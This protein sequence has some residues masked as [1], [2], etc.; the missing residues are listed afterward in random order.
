MNKTIAIVVGLILLGALLL[1]S[2]TY[3]VQYHEVAIKTRFGQT[4]D[5]SIIDEPGLKFRLPLFADKVTTLD[6]RLQ[7]RESPLETV[8]TS[9]GQ[10]VLVKAF[11]LWQV[12]TS[13]PDGQGPLR[14]TKSFGSIDEANA[15]MADQ[16]K[17][18]MRNGLS[19]FTFN[20]LIGT[21]SRLADAEAAIKNEMMGL[22]I[23]GVKPVT[24]GVSQL[25]LPPRTAQAV[26]TRMQTTR[27]VQSENE[28][29]KGQAQAQSIQN[30]AKTQADKIRS[31]ADHRAAEI[32]A[33]GERDAAKYYAL[34]NEEREL[35]IF[36]QEI[37]GLR[38]AL[39]RYVTVVLPANFAPFH[40]MNL[41]TPTNGNGVPIPPTTQPG[42]AGAEVTPADMLLKRPDGRGP[43]QEQDQ[44][45]EQSEQER[46]DG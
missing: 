17:T 6:K 32:R 43:N 24:V 44:Q 35:A 42:V 31:F 40:F 15:A 9:D 16:F 4:T 5:S 20:D 37:E 33:Q 23:K 19:H 34:M 38:T 36:L 29:N 30:R 27:S 18:A 3:T 21:Q 7:L 28:R 41:H 45:P 26:L 11:L 25:V 46:A 12:D 39:S 22:E 1:F 10:Q 14:F 8:Q 13:S 2:A